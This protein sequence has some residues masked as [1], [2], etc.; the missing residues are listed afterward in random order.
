MARKKPAR[1]MAASENAS[2]AKV[3]AAKPFDINSLPDSYNALLSVFKYLPRQDLVR[4]GGVCKFWRQVSLHPS[5]WKVVSLKN[6]KVSS[7]PGL[8]RALNS[9]PEVGVWLDFRKMVHLNPESPG[10]TW[11]KVRDIAAVLANKVER[12]ELPKVPAAHLNSIVEQMA[13]SPI[14]RLSR[15]SAALI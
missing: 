7:W 6:V 9:L 14:S 4:A 2:A 5:L 1:E 12:I 8:A 10:E 11:A 15:V 3:V 13:N